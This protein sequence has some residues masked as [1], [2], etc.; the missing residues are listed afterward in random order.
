MFQLL[1]PLAFA[2]AVSFDSSL[3]CP[4]GS[5]ITASH[6]GSWCLPNECDANECNEGACVAD[7]GLCVTREEV[8]CGGRVADSA[9]CTFEKVEAH[10]T[11]DE[12][13]DCT[14][15]TCETADRCATA[16]QRA[17]GGCA[18]TGAV[19]LGALLLAFAGVLRRRS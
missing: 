1:I 16:K 13:S 9:D 4:R 18:T 2:D 15:G 14:T 17:C 19:G 11:C 7:V 8:A 5:T 10:K 12:Q 3:D 6:I